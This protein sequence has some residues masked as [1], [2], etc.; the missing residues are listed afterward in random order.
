MLFVIK[1]HVDNLRRDRIAAW[2]IVEGFRGTKEMP[3]VADFYPLPYD[4][5]IRAADKKD[6]QQSLDDWYNMASNDLSNFN[7]PER[8][9]SKN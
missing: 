2:K 5:E 1:G 7:W 3:E 9:A 4:D 6:V 8:P